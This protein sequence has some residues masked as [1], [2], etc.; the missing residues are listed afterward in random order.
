MN[1]ARSALG[2]SLPSLF[3]QICDVIKRLVQW[4]FS[5]AQSFM[6]NAASGPAIT[7]DTGR[8]VRIGKQIAEG[9]FSYVFEATEDESTAGSNQQLY[10]LKQIRCPEPNML[11][12]CREEA[13]VHRATM[14]HPNILPLLGFTVVDDIAYMLFPRMNRSLRAEINHRI[15]EAPGDIYNVSR[16]P[17][18]EVDVLNLFL[19][20]ARGLQA[21][22][23]AHY[24]H[25]D[26]KVENIMFEHANSIRTP[27]LMDF[28]SVGPIR[29]EVNTR[30]Q[31][32]NIVDRASQ[33]TT[34]PYRPPELFEGGVRAGDPPVDFASVDMWSLGC[35]FFAVLFGAS[36][37][38]SE[39]SRTNG[40]IRIVDCTQLKVLGGL[41]KLPPKCCAASWYS[42]D[43]LLLIEQML[44]QDRHQRPSLTQIMK[45]IEALIHKMGGRVVELETMDHMA[46]EN[47]DDFHSLLSANRGFP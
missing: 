19:E 44:V 46:D 21:L 40:R 18:N 34:M 37:G 45:Q 41:P 16:A 4:I 47:G 17:W 42:H 3:E 35:T 15:L 6:N 38:E 22:H 1:S 2:G 9:G 24:S 31:A 27:V 36:P 25:R 26:V 43:I 8:R 12:E 32:L 7:M 13:A 11:Q 20:I 28:G 33:H 29:E 14:G 30:R 10:A 5:W 39:F 23:N